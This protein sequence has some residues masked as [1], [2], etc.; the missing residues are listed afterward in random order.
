M[1]TC[2]IHF[3]NSTQGIY[4]SGQT[5]SGRIEL[6]NEKKRKV[7]GITLRIEGYAKVKSKC[8]TQCKSENLF[9]FFIVQ[10]E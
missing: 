6:T 1:V 8:V 9:N 5:L 7:R 10:M 4:Y 3:D 2:N